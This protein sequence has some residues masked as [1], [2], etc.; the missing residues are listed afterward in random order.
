MDS[1]ELFEQKF[2]LPIGTTYNKAQDQYDMCDEYSVLCDVVTTNRYRVW[3]ESWQVC[4]AM[5]Q[6]QVEEANT[7]K[8]YG[9][10]TAKESDKVYQREHVLLLTL[11]KEY[12]TRLAEAQQ[13]IA[14]Q[15]QQI[16]VLRDFVIEVRDDV[17]Y[18]LAHY[19]DIP[20]SLKELGIT[21]EAFGQQTSDLLAQPFDTSALEK[22]RDKVIKG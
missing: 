18:Q 11:Q 21:C 14:A 19:P 8:K 16:A 13:T 15:Q 2:P 17:L 12:N 5:M 9:W 6:K 3:Q 20:I 1:R 22:Y 10:E 4:E 7:N